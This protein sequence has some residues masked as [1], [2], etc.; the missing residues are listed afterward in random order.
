MPNIIQFNTGAVEYDI[1]GT[2]VL[3]NPTDYAFV[4]RVFN[5]FDTMDKMQEQ[6]NDEL[7]TIGEDP[8]KMFDFYHR[9]EDKM[10]GLI[11]DV[12]DGGDVCSSIFG[13]VS[14]FALSDGFPLWA[15]LMLALM[16]EMDVAFARE[17][18]LTN[19]RIKKY[20]AKYEKRGKK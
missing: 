19:P 20:T 5:T 14:V 7:Q 1:N 16:D 18:K 4:E 8:E 9:M 3:M 6:Y 2:K 10:R 12:F 17:K 11:N 15:N 13:R